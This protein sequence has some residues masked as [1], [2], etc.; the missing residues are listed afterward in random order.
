MVMVMVEWAWE[1]WWSGRGNH[2]GV[3][4]GTMVVGV[5]AVVVVAERGGGIDDGG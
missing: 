1:P 3:G 5:H 2:G 4:V